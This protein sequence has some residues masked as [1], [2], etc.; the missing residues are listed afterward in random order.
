MQI[1]LLAAGRGERFLVEGTLTPKLLLKAN[2]QRMISMAMAQ[3]LEIGYYPIVVCMEQLVADFTYHTPPLVH[4]IFAPIR[5][6]Q[7]GAAMSLLAATGKLRDDQPVLV[8][9]CDTI[10]AP[11]VLGQFTRFADTA[12]KT[13]WDSA[14]LCFKPK[15]DSAR[16]SFAVIDEPVSR[17]R[18]ALVVTQIVEKQRI[19]DTATCGVHAFATWEKARR[20][21]YEMVILGITTNDEYYLAPVHNNLANVTAMLIGAAEF[22]HVGTPA[23]LEA[24]EQTVSKA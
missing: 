2:G 16:Y 6:T 7:Q 17:A 11:G 1:V 8:M 18:K 15:D 20:A 19:S 22:T 12:F 23:E 13:G 14:V 4:P 10:F 21:I 24:Y 5:Y 9:D 3:T